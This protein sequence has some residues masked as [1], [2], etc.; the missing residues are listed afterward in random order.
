MEEEELIELE[1]DAWKVDCMGAPWGV[2]KVVFVP[3]SSA[4]GA[5]GGERLVFTE[6]GF[7]PALLSLPLSPFLS[8]ASKCAIQ[9]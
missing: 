1:D 5:G 2:R 8:F 9:L 7:L 3:E 4:G 6:V